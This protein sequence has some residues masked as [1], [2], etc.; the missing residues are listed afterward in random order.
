MDVDFTTYH[1]NQ[2]VTFYVENLAFHSTTAANDITGI[3][4]L[5]DGNV[6]AGW[7]SKSTDHLP[8]NDG[9][10]EVFGPVVLWLDG[11][12]FYVYM[13]YLNLPILVAT[14]GSHTIRLQFR[15]G[16]GA[17]YTTVKDLDATL[18]TYVH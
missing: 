5:L 15:A 10:E 13:L 1:A 2:L 8:V 7:T 9:E 16:N 14:A 6:V 18:T 17:S 3:R 4:V 12:N 11:T